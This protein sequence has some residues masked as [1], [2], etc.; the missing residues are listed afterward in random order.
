MTC[1]YA[2]VPPDIESFQH[3][4]NNETG[5]QGRVLESG[6]MNSEVEKSREGRS[7][8]GLAGP[9]HTHGHW[10]KTI[11]VV[12]EPRGEAQSLDAVTIAV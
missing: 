3:W 10:A 1:I 7:R 4:P 9:K 11:S 12:I 8:P 5:V 6:D 2:I